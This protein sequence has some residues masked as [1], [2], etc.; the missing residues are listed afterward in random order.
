MEQT[1]GKLFNRGALLNVA[2][3]IYKNKTKYFLT[4]DVDLNP[5]EKCVKK[6]YKK[7]V[8][9]NSVLGIYTSFHN[10]LGGVIK[11][12]SETIHK[13]NGFPNDMW[14]WGVE[15]K[16]LQNRAEFF[17]VKKITNLTD[18]LEHLDYFL[19]IKISNDSEYLN[20]EEKT[21][22]HYNT[23]K[24]L[25]DQDK[26]NAIIETGISNLKYKII[27]RRYLNNMVEAITVEL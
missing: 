7:E 3:K 14:G 13:I 15:D 1:E 27:K 25:S 23:F 22:Y 8:D 19:K 26:L 20:L 16:A 17:C 11:I 9:L 18:N 21:K 24:K 12:R 10:T 2:F 5:T 6:F 4:Q